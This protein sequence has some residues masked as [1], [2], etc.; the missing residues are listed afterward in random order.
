MPTFVGPRLDKKMHWKNSNRCLSDLYKI[1]LY[2]PRPR[3]YPTDFMPGKILEEW[4]VFCKLRHF[5]ECRLESS[6]EVVLTLY[7]LG[8]KF[9]MIVVR[10]AKFGLLS[11][12][13]TIASEFFKNYIFGLNFR[14]ITLNSRSMFVRLE[15]NLKSRNRP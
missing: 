12:N 5:C 3:G 8:N 1:R 9:D 10:K 2:N 15:T 11:K 14:K 4:I 6:N 7:P 13:C